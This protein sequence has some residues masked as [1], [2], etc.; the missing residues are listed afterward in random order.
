MNQKLE[1]T[2]TLNLFWLGREIWGLGTAQLKG[3]SSVSYLN[4]SF[5][6]LSFY[7]ACHGLS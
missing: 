2:L 4:L 6:S 7:W 1:E 5:M 3:F